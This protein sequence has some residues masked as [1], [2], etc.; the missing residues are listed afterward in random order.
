M[1]RYFQHLNILDTAFGKVTEL[2]YID[3]NDPEMELYYFKDGS[4]CNKSFIGQ[5]NDMKAF[6]TNKELVEISSPDNRWVFTQQQPVEQN[7][8]QARDKDGQQVTVYNPYSTGKAQPPKYVV[9][10][11]PS[12]VNRPVVKEPEKPAQPVKPQFDFS[13]PESVIPEEVEKQVPVITAKKEPVSKEQLFNYIRYDEKA[14]VFTILDPKTNKTFTFTE[15]ELVT[16]LC[17]KPEELIT[18]KETVPNDKLP[19]GNVD[20]SVITLLENMIAMAKKDECEIGMTVTLKIPSASIYNIICNDYQDGMNDAFIK[21]IA[22][23]VSSRSLR[24]WVAAG[25]SAYYQGDIEAEDDV[26]EEPEP[27]PAPAPMV[28][29]VTA[30]VKKRPSKKT[31]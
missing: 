12:I 3:N 24:E 28:K 25:L 13:A 21:I 4:K 5:L 2:D 26:D 9:S 31:K 19:L 7:H 29:A 11:R 30:N 23:K 17:Q 10:K 16:K 20:A 1:A 15:N 6:E 8:I 14:G 22:N 27:E 18:T